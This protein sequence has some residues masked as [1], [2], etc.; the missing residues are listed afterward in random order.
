ML[1]ITAPH[2][3]A[4]VVPGQYA[5]PIVAYMIAWAPAAIHDYCAVKGWTV[6]RIP[7]P[8]EYRAEPFHP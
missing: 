2:F 3:V 8:D 1:R 7:A 5:A 6:E 4:G